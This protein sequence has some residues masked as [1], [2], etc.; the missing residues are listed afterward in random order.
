[1]GLRIKSSGCGVNINSPL[2]A[3]ELILSLREALVEIPVLLIIVLEFQLPHSES[4]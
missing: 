4:I 2:G 1:M 3:V